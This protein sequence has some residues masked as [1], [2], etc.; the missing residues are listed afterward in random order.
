MGSQTGTWFFLGFMVVL[1]TLA[2]A[3]VQTPPTKTLE[4]TLTTLVATSP[5]IVQGVVGGLSKAYYGTHPAFPGGEKIIESDRTIAVERVFKGG[6]SQSSVLV[7]VAGGCVGGICFRTD[8]DVS[9]PEGES[10]I[11]F[12]APGQ[13]GKWIVP[14]S[15]SGIQQGVDVTLLE[16]IIGQSQ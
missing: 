7:Q 1:A 13:D 15:T 14:D 11:L 3:S 4:Q 6:I 5:V 10:V 16:T 2:H 12:L 9:L 8:L